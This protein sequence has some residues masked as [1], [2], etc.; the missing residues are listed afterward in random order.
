M[1]RKSARQWKLYNQV[2]FREVET[3]D[4]KESIRAENGFRNHRVRR[5]RISTM[6]G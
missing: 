3:K 4:G 2:Q 1:N 5:E 6:H